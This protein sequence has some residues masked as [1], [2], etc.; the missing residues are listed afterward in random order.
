MTKKIFNTSDSSKS[1]YD[2]RNDD[3]PIAAL[4]LRESKVLLKALKEKAK[5]QGHDGAMHE[6]WCDACSTIGEVRRHIRRITY[7]GK[8]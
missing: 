5:A 8:N 7:V 2:P 1:Q 3:R 6:T 4:P